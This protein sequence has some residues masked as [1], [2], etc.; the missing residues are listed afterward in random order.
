MKPESADFRTRIWNLEVVMPILEKLWCAVPQLELIEGGVPWR[1]S[2][3]RT[4]IPVS[5]KAHLVTKNSSL[6]WFPEVC[7]R[8]LIS[9]DSCVMIWSR[10]KT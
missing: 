5:E 1:D 3:G 6:I 9:P 2:R 8:T 4:M 10:T 7:A